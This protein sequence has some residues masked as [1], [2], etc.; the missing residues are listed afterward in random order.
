MNKKN[1]ISVGIL[2]ILII[3]FIITKT[4][5]YKEKRINFF[6]VDSSKIKVIELITNEDTLKLVNN[7]Q[8]WMIDYPIKYKTVKRKIDDFFAKVLK[9]ETSS[10]PISESKESFKIYNV[11][12][13]LGTQVKLYDEQMNLL[14]DVIIGKSDN[15]NFSNARK[16]GESKIYQLL[17]NVSYNFKPDIYSWRD[18]EIL[19]LQEDNLSKIF[20]SFG[21]NGYSLIATDSLWEYQSGKKK[22]FVKE[23]NGTL[24]SIINIC[25]KLN[26]SNFID[27]KYE[28]Y[29]NKFKKPYLEL[30]LELANGDNIHLTFIKYDDKDNKFILKKDEQTDPLFVLNKNIVERFKKTE[31]DFKK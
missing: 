19:N 1:L 30:T 5:N 16:N 27:N 26:A 24:K 29:E 17:S 8:G 18:K 21:K 25:K 10:I 15:Y 23:K 13:S 11:S 12:D 28:T 3:V 14:S 20:V 7:S 31:K 9:A 6:D 2:A 22:F 4:H